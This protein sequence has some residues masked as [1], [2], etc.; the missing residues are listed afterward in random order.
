M[1]K[2]WKEEKVTYEMFVEW[3][4]LMYS[5]NKKDLT[6]IQKL[7]KLLKEAADRWPANLQAHLFIACIMTKLPDKKIADSI[8]EKFFQESLIRKFTL[9]KEQNMDMMI[10]FWQ[11]Y[12]DWSVQNKTSYH[13]ILKLVNQL[14]NVCINAPKRMSD[15]FKSKILSIF[16]H[17]FG[18]EKSR[19]YYEKN[20]TV[21]PICK[22]FSYKMIEIE[23]HYAEMQEEKS[24]QLDS[25]I[26]LIYDD[27]IHHFGSDDVHIWLACL[28]HAMIVDAV[29]VGS[30]YEKALK[31]LKPSLCQQFVQQYSLLKLAPLYTMESEFVSA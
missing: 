8:I 25:R 17:L 5:C 24:G 16:Y 18:I 19:S 10:D 1:E 7:H 12:L 20:K 13:K 9:V 26:S 23:K 4:K 3:V 21:S 11:L 22:S 14:N 6:T 29:K 15:H 27:L 28:R 30:F 31:S 2:L